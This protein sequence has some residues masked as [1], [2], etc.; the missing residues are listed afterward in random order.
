VS[1]VQEHSCG[2]P[3]RLIID[4]DSP[5]LAQ[6]NPSSESGMPQ[7]GHTTGGSKSGAQ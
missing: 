7:Y 4:T 6:T 2:M 5:S 1:N 3:S